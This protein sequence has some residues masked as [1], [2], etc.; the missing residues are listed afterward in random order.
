ME[1][2][3][4][5]QQLLQQIW[6]IA[7]SFCVKDE[8]ELMGFNLEPIETENKIMLFPKKQLKNR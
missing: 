2:K 4:S 7:N 1:L 3:T 6:V 5:T 8:P